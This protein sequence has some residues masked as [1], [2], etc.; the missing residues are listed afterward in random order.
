[1]SMSPTPETQAVWTTLIQ[2]ADGARNQVESAL[3]DASLPPLSWYD[4]LLE[5]ERAG[6]TGLRAYELKDRLLMPQYGTSRLLARI[7]GAGLILRKACND[8]ARGQ[9]I[10]LTEKGAETR[11]R[12]WPV[13]A[14]AMERAIGS[15]LKP[16]QLG[17]LN[18]LL[19]KL[20]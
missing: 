19:G 14:N 5:I 12:M 3:A 1:M 10:T 13:Y 17:R 2:A 16:V 7:E 6:P 8:D 18:R 4:A 9:I 15:K 20:L 11:Q